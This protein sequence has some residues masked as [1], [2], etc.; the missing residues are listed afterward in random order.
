MPI[1]IKRRRQH[2][3]PSSNAAWS[4]L[5]L[6]LFSGPS[7]SLQA[8]CYSTD[9]RDAKGE[10]TDRQETDR[11]EPEADTSNT[12]SRFS[13]MLGFQSLSGLF[14]QSPRGRYSRPTRSS[15][16]RNSAPV[17]SKPQPEEVVPS[18][19]E[20]SFVSET[21]ASQPDEPVIAPIPQR[22]RYV[23]EGT[24]NNT[25]DEPDS[26]LAT[27]TGQETPERSSRHRRLIR[28]YGAP[29]FKSRP[30]PGRV[31]NP[32][33][34]TRSPQRRKTSESSESW[35]LSKD[36][37]Q[38]LDSMLD[39]GLSNVEFKP[40]KESQQS[41]EVVPLDSS[42]VEK[43]AASTSGS[44]A[45]E[46]D[47][48]K[49]KLTH[50]TS[51]GEAHMV[52][53]GGKEHTKRIAIAF[54]KVSFSNANPAR[55]ILENT[56]KKGDALGVARIAGIMASKRTADLIPLCHPIPISRVEVDVQLHPPGSYGFYASSRE[57]H[58][59]VTIHAIVECVG[60]TG[61]EM[62]ALTAVSGAALTVFD[63]CKAV[64]RDIVVGVTKVMYKSGGRSGVHLHRKWFN[65]GGK[66]F[67]QKVRVDIDGLEATPVGTPARTRKPLR[68]RN[69]RR[70][71]QM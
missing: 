60:P 62:E 32:F 67:L 51:S 29:V 56:N 7:A 37:H 52:N 45:P 27:H 10:E 18:V 57:H 50:V 40:V 59:V 26:N 20:P 5:P 54:A 36:T 49:S 41:P 17:P 55:L 28:T 71:P 13:S 22:V 38:S 65:Y 44:S 24:Q 34:N 53:V 31:A 25:A 1:A 42:S 68:G 58:G 19:P 63:M 70:G 43:P 9:G 35:G 15:T 4:Q 61:V 46:S 66:Q 6:H 12:P 47:Q 23:S 64:D 2:V 39:P 21:T 3:S 8:R 16:T 48:S 14:Q 33:V 30:V 69:I 11:Q